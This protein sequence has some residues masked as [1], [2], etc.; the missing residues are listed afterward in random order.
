MLDPGEF[1]LLAG[2]LGALLCLSLFGFIRGATRK[3]LIAD[4]PTSRVR[5][6]AQGYVE[7][8]GQA[9]LMEGPPI[10]APL[11]GTHCAWYSYRIDRRDRTGS[12]RRSRQ[13]WTCVDQ[14]TST[15]LFYLVDDTGECVV[16]PEG[17]QVVHVHQDR[18]H[19]DSRRPLVGPG[20]GGTF[21]GAGRYRYTE[22]RLHLDDDLYA[23]GYF[24]SHVTGD[25]TTLNTEVAQILREWKKD[26]AALARF[27]ANGD[28]EICLEEWEAARQ[29]ATDQALMQRAERAMAPATHLLSRGPDRRR[30]YILS[31]L[32]EDQLVTRYRWMARLSGLGF[33]LSVGGLAWLFLAG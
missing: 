6:A 20:G 1:W 25:E 12:G 32:P 30:P 14:G 3:R 29:A 23:I 19:G 27:D 33:L 18:W 8:I 11:T 21:L 16:D 26:P 7:L 4:T 15:D 28:G 17:A 2:L 24:R 9:R 31:A 22:N 10:I 13:R 5:S